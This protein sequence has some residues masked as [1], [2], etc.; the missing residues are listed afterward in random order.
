MKKASLTINIYDY[1]DHRR[2]LNDAYLDLHRQDA[3][4]SY[5]YLQKKAGYSVNSNH[6]WQL[7]KGRIPM[8]QQ[9]ARR[10]GGALG[11][12][13]KQIQYL[14]LLASFAQADSDADKNHC[15]EQLKQFNGFK[16]RQKGKQIRYEFYEDWRLPALRELVNLDDFKEDG[17][18]MSNR[19]RL[20][21]TAKQAV[22]GVAKLLSLGFLV[23]DESGKLK[24]ADPFIGNF[25]DSNQ[26][27]EPASLA[28]RNF[29]RQMIELGKLCIDELEQDQR[30]VLGLTMSISH[31]Q[32]ES[33]RELTREYMKQVEGILLED[34][35]VEVV[36]RLNVQMFP[37]S[38][39][40]IKKQASGNTVGKQAIKKL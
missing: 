8:S 4:I 1:T 21:L 11:L 33:I 32:S 25:D 14:S 18:W 31:K 38:N 28:L 35:P 3:D 12:N 7:L 37:L 15:L 9:A 29:H 22:K 34:Q 40:K 24:Q 30:L 23:R 20:H 13:V 16:N 19:M 2:F 36:Q 26:D 39:V 5:R 27:S 10:F 17:Q 6:F